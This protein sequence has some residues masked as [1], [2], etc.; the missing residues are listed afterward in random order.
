MIRYY[1]A[2]ENTTLR[3]VAKEIG[4]SPATLMRI[5]HGMEPDSATLIKLLVWMFGAN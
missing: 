3:D 5:S 2:C 4:T 1:L